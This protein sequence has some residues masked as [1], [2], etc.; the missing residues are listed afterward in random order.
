MAQVAFIG[1]GMMGA[2]M[3]RHLGMAGHDV[4]DFNRTGAKADAWIE[5]NGGRAAPTPRRATEG[6]AFVF[7]CVGND[8]DFRDVVLGHDRAGIR[9]RRGEPHAG[10]PRAAR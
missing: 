1:L 8:S 7:V 3:E 6:A 10:T 9:G 2:A 5:A 4:T